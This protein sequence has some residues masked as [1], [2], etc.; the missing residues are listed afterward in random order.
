MHRKK[1]YTHNYIKHHLPCQIIPDIC[2][3]HA[4]SRRLLV[5]FDY[6]YTVFS[7]LWHMKRIAGN[8]FCTGGNVIHKHHLPHQILRNHRTSSYEINTQLPVLYARVLRKNS[9]ILIIKRYIKRDICKYFMWQMVL[10]GDKYLAT[11]S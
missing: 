7:I 5:P 1:C 3:Y 2:R 9:S 8:S 6:L 10:P 11:S 4:Q